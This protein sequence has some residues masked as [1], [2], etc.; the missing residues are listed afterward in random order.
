MDSFRLILL[1]VGAAVGGV[2]T[3]FVLSNANGGPAAFVADGRWH[4]VAVTVDRDTAGLVSEED[5]G[6]ELVVMDRIVRP[7]FESGP[8]GR[9]SGPLF[10]L[11]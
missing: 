8:R 7:P 3:N 6:C 4:L 1:A 11:N 9:T 10:V 2:A 5:I